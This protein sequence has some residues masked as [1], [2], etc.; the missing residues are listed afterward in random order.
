VNRS[1]AQ[2]PPLNAGRRRT[3]VLLAGAG[4][5]LYVG[6][7]IATDA[8]R[9]AGALR[10]LGLIG[11]VSILALSAVN[12]LV[13]FGRWQ[14]Y[15]QV[16]GHQLPRRELLLCY[17]SGFAFTVSPGRAG[18]AMRSLYL[19]EHGVTYS[20]SIATLFVERMLDLLT[21]IVLA[22][23]VI[24]VSPAYSWVLVSMAV[25]AIVA[26]IIICHPALPDWLGGLALR[27]E[28][29]RSAKWLAGAANLLRASRTLLHPKLLLFGM[30]L[31]IASWGAEGLGFHLVCNGLNFKLM[32][33]QA[34]GIYGVATLLG[35]AAI[36]LPAGIGGTEAVMTTLLVSSGASLSDAVIATLLCR[37]ATLWFAVIIGLAAT[38][39]LE[40]LRSAPPAGSRIS[41]E[42]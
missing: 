27:R 42:N 24:L 21:M 25:A 23:L 7:A 26:L 16:L 15:L 41:S 12:Y 5:A 14:L 9:L 33:A 13:R 11:I 17:L 22:S 2:A 4:V 38:A 10:Q 32:A 8:A 37:L 40:L 30:V 6:V 34:V 35:V 36:F 19:R 3:L 31:G 20:Q 18:E 39:I 28:G 29:H 1:D